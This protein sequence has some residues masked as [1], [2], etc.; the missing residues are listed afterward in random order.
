MVD[1]VRIVSM[2]MLFEPVS[3]VI[4]AMQKIVGDCPYITSETQ[5]RGSY[6][7]LM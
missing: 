3:N 6:Q 7:M 2:F 1:A 4:Y 5:V